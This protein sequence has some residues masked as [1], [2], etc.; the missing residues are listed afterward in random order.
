MHG[1]FV[2][3]CPRPGDP[4]PTLMLE[5]WAQ[6]SPNL[7]TQIFS[8]EEEACGGYSD[9]PARVHG[10]PQFHLLGRGAGPT[11]LDAD[12][13]ARVAAAL[14]APD[15]LALTME[16]LDNSWGRLDTYLGR[17]PGEGIAIREADR[18]RERVQRRSVPSAA[19]GARKGRGLGALRRGA[20]RPYRP[21]P[22]RDHLRQYLFP[23]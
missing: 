3:A 5:A 21:V 18:A 15:M 23:F 19:G 10:T 4:A 12:A 14:A 6:R 16:D 20:L 9:L 7:Y 1:R 13:Y 11:R 2:M 8:R 17:Q 22:G